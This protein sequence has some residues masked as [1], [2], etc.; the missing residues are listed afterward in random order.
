MKKI[1]AV[2]VLLSMTLFAEV[3]FTDMFDA[4]DEAKAQKK[5]V[6]VMLSQEGCS[7][8]EYMKNVVYKNKDVSKYISDNYIAVYLDIYAEPVPEE[9]E[10]FATPTYYFLDEDENILKRINGGEN[11]KDFL[12]SLQSVNESFKAKKH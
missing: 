4:Y 1:A 9:L 8:C 2:L 10:H 3:K 5:L 12:K 6:L 7:G 11:A